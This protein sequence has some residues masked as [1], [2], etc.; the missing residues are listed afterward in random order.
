MTPRHHRTAIDP[1]SPCLI[2]VAQQTWRPKEE[3]SPEPLAMWEH[4]CRA[5]AAD[6][7]RT[8]VL[9]HVDSVR[10]VY[11]QSWQY[12][13]PT[14]RLAD[15]LGIEARHR[16]YS[17]IG[18]TTPQLLVQDAAAA[19]LRGE[20]DL[21]LVAGAEAL[22]T[23]RLLA[24][25]G[26]TPAWSHA[27]PQAPPMPFEAPPHPAE[28]AHELSSASLPFSLF[29]IG[30][31]AARGVSPQDYRRSLG[32]LLSAMTEV[33]ATNPHAKFPFRRSADEIVTPTAENRWIN[34]PY[35]KWMV[36]VM[37]VD[38]A[39]ALLLATHN[40]ADEL[41]IPAERRVYLRGWCYAQDPVYLAEHPSFGASVAMREASSGALGMA[42]IAADDVAHLDL[43]SCF[44]AA[45]NLGRDA[46]QRADDDPRPV[47]VTG[48][49][50][51]FGGPASNYMTHSIASIADVLRHD[52]G[53][54]G[55]VS[56]VGMF[57][58][59]HVY[60][61]YSTEPGPMTPPDDTA[62]QVR[63]DKVSRPEIIDTYEGPALIA[64]YSV[65]H[66]RDG[67]PDGGFVICDLPSGPRCYAR[68]VDVDLMAEAE[69]VELVGR[70]VQLVPGD[71]NVNVV[72]P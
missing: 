71:A 68:I 41:G 29:D 59:K 48:G 50:P 66:G 67:T 24:K 20:L 35:T 58:T 49:L 47:T 33:A 10:I 72:K 2:G 18:G 44:S 27:H 45:V 15:E 14:A 62:A 3:A 53:S 69:E 51:Y 37:D 63:V 38:M 36:S 64:T 5:A 12:D 16:H 42:G 40:K 30:R 23:M 9:E 56:G 32:H 60:G 6:T 7:G 57:M 28:I 13:D 11:C 1:R 55:I 34:Y 19:M 65:V 54:Y 70:A 22:D 4:V 43:Y 25:D 26:R 61:V 31:R 8:G 46:L 39:G 21:A 52:P 17:G